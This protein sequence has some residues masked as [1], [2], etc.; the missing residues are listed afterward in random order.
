MTQKNKVFWFILIL[1]CIGFSN[2]QKQVAIDPPIIQSI[3]LYQPDINKKDSLVTM[4]SSKKTVKIVVATNGELCSV[5]PAGNRLTVK[6]KI[7]PTKDSLDGFNHP[8]LVRSD[9]YRDYDLPFAHGQIMTGTAV[10][11]Y[12]VIYSA[13]TT[14]GSYTMTIISTKH[15]YSE[16]GV[17]QALLNQTVVVQ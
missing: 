11:G 12:S 6:S 10:S 13:Y 1:F 8:Y 9:D 3:S 7:D 17:V 14:A 16:P 4:V 15:G 2:C 5:W